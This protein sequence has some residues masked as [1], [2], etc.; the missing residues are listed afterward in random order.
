MTDQFHLRIVV[1]LSKNLEYPL[2]SDMPD[3]V[4]FDMSISRVVQ[5]VLQQSRKTET[6]LA[7]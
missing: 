5:L 1:K 3:F 6:L 4:W 7:Q 2:Y